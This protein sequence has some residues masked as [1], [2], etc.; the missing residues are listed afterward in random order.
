[1]QAD[2]ILAI[3]NGTQSVRAIVIDL[4]GQILAK[5]KILMEEY[6][7]PQLGWS[8]CDPRSFWRDFN[9]VCQDL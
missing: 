2:T 1:M 8:E 4:Q 6:Q 7:T 5:S 9:R 3:D